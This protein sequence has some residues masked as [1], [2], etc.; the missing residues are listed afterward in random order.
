MATEQLT[1]D[2]FATLGRQVPVASVEG[3]LRKLWDEDEAS[4]RAS[5]MNL[6][7]Y[8]E[9]S[10]QLLENAEL[11][12]RLTQEHACRAI[13]IGLEREAE[14]TTAQAWI[15]AHCHLA[16][17]KKSICSEQV[18]FLLRGFS[19]GRMR[20]TV[21]ANTA[22]DL[23]LVFWWQGELS[24]RFS[25]GLYSVL[26]RLIFD[27]STWTDL[28][29]SFNTIKEARENT[30]SHFV[31]QDLSW[32]RSFCYR[33]AIAGLFDDPVAQQAFPSVEKV[34]I[35]G[36][37][38]HRA[39]VLML[40][41]WLGKM[42]GWSFDGSSFQGDEGQKIEIEFDWDSEGAPIGEVRVSAP[43]FELTVSRKPGA[44]ILQ[45]ELV[46]GD[47]VVQARGP[48]D[49]D[50]PIELVASQLSRGGKNSLFLRI[51]PTFRELLKPFGK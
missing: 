7:V 5:L 4:T 33:L 18:A 34:A 50:E 19:R 16:H 36:Q 38:Q 42:A 28:E 2:Q 29:S 13:L 46:A 6:L 22:S 31:T 24:P 23:P 51:L 10:K 3:E 37:P 32:T 1:D 17:G 25:N 41:A 15:T 44:Q 20:N 30:S 26:D 45:Q 43:N 39:A 12:P 9:D 21:F 35:T 49:A 14:E 47:H 8:T 48:A 40:I 11:L 27:S